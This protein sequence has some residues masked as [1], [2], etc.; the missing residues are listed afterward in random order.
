MLVMVM[1]VVVVALSVDV[2]HTTISRP[3]EL[4]FQYFTVSEC[5]CSACFP[6]NR[7]GC[8]NVVVV[9]VLVVVESDGGGGFECGRLTPPS[10]LSC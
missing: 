7:G 6:V 4:T 3:V 5:I 9:V 1:V 10:V 2:P 8:D